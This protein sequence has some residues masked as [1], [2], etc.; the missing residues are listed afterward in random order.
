MSAQSDIGRLILGDRLY[1]EAIQNTFGILAG[2]IDL[3]K[4]YNRYMIIKLLEWNDTENYLTASQLQCL[5]GIVQRP[6]KNCNC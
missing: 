3:M 6:A 2:N 4:E 1:K 5:N